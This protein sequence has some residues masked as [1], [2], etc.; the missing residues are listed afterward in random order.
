MSDLFDIQPAVDTILNSNVLA[1]AELPPG[2]SSFD[3]GDTD[4]LFAKN[5]PG[6]M[7]LVGQRSILIQGTLNGAVGN[8]S[9]IA[10]EGDAIITGDVRHAHIS[11]RHLHIGGR[12]DHSLISAVGD[13]TIGAEL[14]HTHLTVGSYETRRHRIEGLRAELIRQ[15]DKRTASDRRISQEEKRLDR[16]CKVTHIPL[17]F[18]ISRIITQANNRVVVN[19]ATFYGSLNEQSEE[20]LRRGLNEFFAKGIIGYLAK[21]NRKYII[22]NPAR[23]KVFLQ[24][25]KN[26]RALVMEVFARDRLIAIIDRDREEMDRLLT[27]LR[28]QNSRIH[29]RGAILPDTEMEF[30]LPR[31][32][33]LENGEINFVHQHALLNVQAGSKSGRLKLAATDSA[34]EPSSTEIKTVEFCRQSFHVDQGEVARNPAPMGA[35]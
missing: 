9:K 18:N 31:I 12:L 24:L 19:L 32:L 26:L 6:G 17:D 14:A 30:V 1:N 15:Q 10:V 29:V 5:V 25:L 22:D 7:T 21:A 20:K 8:T 34:G 28:E 35:S 2:H 13:I 11:C 23:E 33:H 27:E 3:A 4:A 16:S